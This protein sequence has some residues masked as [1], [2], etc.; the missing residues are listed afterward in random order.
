MFYTSKSEFDYCLEYCSVFFSLNKQ[1]INH[2]GNPFKTIV[3]KRH[4]VSELKFFS[5]FEI[6]LCQINKLLNVF[7]QVVFTA[8]QI[9]HF[10]FCLGRD[11][12]VETLIL[13]QFGACIIIQGSTCVKNI[14]EKAQRSAE[15]IS[16]PQ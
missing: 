13:L 11:R 7:I 4:R 16:I 5:S 2:T 10:F 3:L 14:R 8:N 6:K 12:P 9:Q 15:F 1:R